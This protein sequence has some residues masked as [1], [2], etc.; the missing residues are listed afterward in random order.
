MCC[1]PF[2]SKFYAESK[3]DIIFLCLGNPLTPIS[4]FTAEQ[5]KISKKKTPQKNVILLSIIFFFFFFMPSDRP[6]AI[7]HMKFSD[8]GQ[9]LAVVSADNVIQY[10]DA[11]SLDKPGPVY[12]CHK[13]IVRSVDLSHDCKYLL[14][15]SDDKTCKLWS[16]KKTN[17]ILIDIKSIKISD[18]KVLYI[19]YITGMAV[20]HRSQISQEI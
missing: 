12:N 10:L 14:S 13:D 6:S 18:S 2:Y 3:Y 5:I 17:E 9:N 15:T 16:L 4:G 1:I 19:D 20:G 11:S 7:T 8:D